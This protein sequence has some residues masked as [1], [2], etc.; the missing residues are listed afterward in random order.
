MMIDDA[1]IASFSLYS[2][3]LADVSPWQSRFGF[4]FVSSN[5]NA[6]FC[7]A[8]LDWNLETMWAEIANGC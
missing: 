5:S 4:Y 1:L 6:G 3:H 2:R 7:I 8:T